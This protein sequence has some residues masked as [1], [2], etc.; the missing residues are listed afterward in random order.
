[1]KM[2]KIMMTYRHWRCY[3]G[4]GEDVDDDDDCNDNDDDCNDNDDDG[5]SEDND[6]DND[7]IKVRYTSR[8]PYPTGR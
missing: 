7:D 4:G 6:D 3:D 8:W 5:G 2:L 1:M